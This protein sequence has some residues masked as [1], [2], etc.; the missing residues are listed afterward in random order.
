MVLC[1]HTVHMYN[2]FIIDIATLFCVQHLPL[3]QVIVAT[4]AFGMGIDKPDVRFV[5]H[6]SISK[7]I[8]NY[9]QES[10]RAG[11]DGQTSVCILY[12]R[13]ADLFRLTCNTCTCTCML[14]L[15]MIILHDNNG[16][17]GI[18]VST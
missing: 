8:E 18:H 5:I 3:F 11:R 13:L 7:S 16:N 4:V 2:L 17:Y 12:Y 10:G 14:I 6:H 1:L 9:Y 15:A